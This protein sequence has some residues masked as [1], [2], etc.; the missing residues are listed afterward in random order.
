MIGGIDRKFEKYYT[1][2]FWKKEATI[3][4]F[5]K[6]KNPFKKTEQRHNRI[7]IPVFREYGSELCFIEDKRLW[8]ILKSVPY[9]RNFYCSNKITYGDVKDYNI[10]Y[11]QDT[12]IIMTS[13][14][15]LFSKIKLLVK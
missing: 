13:D 4:F 7:S 1:A 8:D 9:N 2:R 12:I 6:Y 10:N 5:K 14:D 11:N 3:L 15:A